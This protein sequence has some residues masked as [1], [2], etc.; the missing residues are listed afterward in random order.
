[1]ALD[2]SRWCYIS[3]NISIINMKRF[4]LIIISMVFLFVG[5]DAV[6]Q[7]TRNADSDYLLLDD[8]PTFKGGSPNDF[9]L[10]VAKHVKYPKYAKETGIEGTVM[11][12]FVIDKNG[13]VAEAH[14]HQGVHPVLDE[15]AVR[16]V[17]NSPKWKPAKKNGRPVRVSYNIPVMFYFRK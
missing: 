15:E 9:A 17:K 2:P 11:V 13:K 6:A 7:D 1:M 12:H 8:H 10:W 5:T 16:V 4:I 3:V 14:V